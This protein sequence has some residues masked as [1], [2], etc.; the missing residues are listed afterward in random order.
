ML[1]A[2]YVLGVDDALFVAGHAPK[3]SE[4]G[5]HTNTNI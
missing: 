4:V 5:S 2:N 1:I 3:S